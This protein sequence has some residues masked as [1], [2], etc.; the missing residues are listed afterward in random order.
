MTPGLSR[1]RGLMRHARTRVAPAPPVTEASLAAE[2]WTWPEAPGLPPQA[3]DEGP[4]GPTDRV[5][6][7]ALLA[8]VDAPPAADMA[9]PAVVQPELLPAADR[10]PRRG[11][12]ARTSGG[13]S[14]AQRYGLPHGTVPVP[15]ATVPVAPLAVA[16]LAVVP[17]SVERPASGPGVFRG[18]VAALV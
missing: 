10:P 9:A 4:W 2:P 14:A 11:R 13:P 15:D 8:P 1:S 12:R 6:L 17:A 3:R 7:S 18:P 5:A 16:P